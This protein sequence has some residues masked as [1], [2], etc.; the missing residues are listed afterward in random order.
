M[1]LGL[2]YVVNEVAMLSEIKNDDSLNAQIL[3]FLKCE[4]VK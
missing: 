3:E 4:L 2:I 1:L